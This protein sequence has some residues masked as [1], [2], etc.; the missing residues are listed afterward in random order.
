MSGT[1]V[2]PRVCGEQGQGGRVED[3]GGGSSPRVRGTVEVAE[4]N[5]VI[6]RFIPACAGNSSQTV[7]I[8]DARPV[9]PRVCGEQAG[10]FSFTTGR[11]GSSP[12][13][14]GTAQQDIACIGVQRFIPACAG[15][16]AGADAAEPA[17]SVHP[18]VCGEQTGTS[19][20]AA[21]ASGSSPRVRGTGF[22]A[23]D[24]PSLARFIPACAGNRL[25]RS[26]CVTKIFT[27]STELP[28]LPPS[29][30]T[31]SYSRG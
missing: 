14:R 6:G 19:P 2:H 17:G 25:P 13:V 18:R 15:N 5:R 31:V 24:R 11:P 10:S 4:P 27:M 29:G 3:G 23:A 7:S 28:I 21:S 26:L 8:R 1:P 22:F 16:S 9:H 20:N 12:R 30:A